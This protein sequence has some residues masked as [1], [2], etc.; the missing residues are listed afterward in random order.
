MEPLTELLEI[1]RQRG[2]D[3]LSKRYINSKEHLLW[4]CRKGHKWES[5]P[6]SVKV[7]K[8]W[9]PVCAG[10][11]PLGLEKMHKLA[12]SRGGKC[13]SVEYFNVKTAMLWQCKNGHQFE[14]TPDNVKQGKWCPS[15]RRKD[16]VQIVL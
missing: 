11:Q 4:Q 1:A 8:S 10:N 7:R 9:S 2:G 16:V 5:T 6:F 13:L 3:C 14:S 12:W 15:C